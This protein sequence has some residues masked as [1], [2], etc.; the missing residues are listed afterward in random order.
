MSSCFFIGSRDAGEELRS[1]VRAAA[2]RLIQDEGVRDFYVG[3][4]GA[5]DHLAASVVMSLMEVH[6]EVRL[7]RVLS[8]FPTGR[9]VPEHPG[10]TGTV[11]PEGLEKVPRR[12]AIQRANRI[13]TDECAF[14]I[15]YAPH[16]FGNARK[17]LEY[18]RR[19]ERRGRIRVIEV[20][21]DSS[22]Q[23]APMAR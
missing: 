4:R 11:F 13:M 23:D 1:E 9:D 12:Y 2:E 14:L 10:F 6:P 3:S 17:I 20:T 18:A 19:Q 21:G 22:A 5:F 16:E 7:Y 15:A 8:D